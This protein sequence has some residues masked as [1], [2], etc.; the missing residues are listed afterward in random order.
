MDRRK[1]LK[2]NRSNV[3]GEIRYRMAHREVQRAARR[4]KARWIEERCAEV[5]EGLQRHNTKNAYELIKTLKNGRQ[6]RQ[7]NLKDADGQVLTDLKDI[8]RRWRDYGQRLYQED[9]DNQGD[10]VDSSPTLGDWPVI[11]ES[12][13]EDSIRRLPKYKA[14]G[15][16]EVPAELYKTDNPM[17]I[18]VLC[19]LCNKIVETGEWPT[20]WMRSIFIPL[21]KIPGTMECQEFRTIAL[22]SHASKILLRILLRRTQQ[23]AEEQF[24][25]VQMGF[26][27]KVGTRDQIFNLRL[28]MEKAHE[29]NVPLFLAFID[30]KKAFDSVQHLKLWA[31]LEKMGVNNTVVSLLRKLYSE[32]EATVKVEKELSNWFPIKKGVR[33]GCLISPMLFNFYS[34]QVM[35]E[36]ADDLSSI[37]VCISGRNFNNL[38]FA[39]D[40]VLMAT[41]ATELQMLLDKVETA[42]NEVKL[43]I[44]ERKT[45]VMTT[46]TSEQLS[47]RCH[48]TVLEKVDRFKYLG[49]IIHQTADTS[50]E[51]WARLGAARSALKSLSTLWKDRALHKNIKVK[52]LKS[53]VWPLALYGCEAWTLKANDISKLRAFEMTCYRR[54]LKIPWTAHRTNES[55]LLELGTQRELVMTVRKRKLQYFGHVTRANNICTH[56]LEGRI[57]GRRSRGRPRRRWT[58][59]IKEWTRRP[60]SECSRMARERSRWR[61]LVYESMV[62]DPQH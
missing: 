8:L 44:N 41:S 9:N 4:D 34:E 51:I 18:K 62:P 11:L 42:S 2:I 56:I 3:D 58:D 12:E 39:D 47:I 29:F 50:Q 33:Q 36:S 19:K 10:T 61:E 31:V 53:L 55:I 27:R 45:K 14:A 43:E 32:Q 52:L 13:V 28:I 54:A 22:I 7:R 24:A 6:T 59:D 15:F 16:D 48:G 1:E 46:A 23:T 37:G 25:D 60:L 40:I 20:D 30:F 26:R 17:M 21:A 57:N 35:R 49:S 38:R 5:Q